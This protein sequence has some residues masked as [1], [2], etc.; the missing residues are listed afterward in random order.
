MGTGELLEGEPE[1][2]LTHKLV[3]S[4]VMQQLTNMH[5]REQRERRVFQ[6]LLL[7]I[8]ELEGC[9]TKES[10]EDIVHIANLVCTVPSCQLAD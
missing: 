7:M 9:L 3:V 6:G 1:E 10:N 4:F 8:P 5:S 2:T